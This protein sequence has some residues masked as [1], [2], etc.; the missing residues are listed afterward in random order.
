MLLCSLASICVVALAGGLFSCLPRQNIALLFVPFVPCFLLG[1]ELFTVNVGRNMG[2][3]CFGVYLLAAV[4]L[5]FVV[6]L[7]F[8]GHCEEGVVPWLSGSFS[9][10]TIIMAVCFFN[11]FH[12]MKDA[13]FTALI[14]RLSP[15]TLGI[16]VLHPLFIRLLVSAGVPGSSVNAEFAVIMLVFVVFIWSAVTVWAIGKIP[17]IRRLVIARR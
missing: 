15:L 6:Y 11:F 4:F 2:K 12:A 17:Y 7:C 8:S 1:Y 3:V 10:F 9:P 16:Y 5:S 14:A 13:R